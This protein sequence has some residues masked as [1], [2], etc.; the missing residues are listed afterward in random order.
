MKRAVALALIL[1][2]VAPAFAYRSQAEL[3]QLSGLRAVSVQ[4]RILYIPVTGMDV[5]NWTYEWMVK[6]MEER[7]VTE[8]ALKFDISGSLR[9]AGLGVPDTSGRA[10]VTCTIYMLCLGQ[11]ALCGF[12]SMELGQTATLDRNSAS[13]QGNISLASQMFYGT[14]DRVAAAIKAFERSTA[15]ALA[16]DCQNAN[17]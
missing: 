4:T 11:T 16:S 2:A 17:K 3:K 7:E 1:L 10:T 8:R 13:T 6:A 9:D 15:D 14:A 12:G 5:A